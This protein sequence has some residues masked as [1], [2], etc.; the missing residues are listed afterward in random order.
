MDAQ[1]SFLCQAI[2]QPSPLTLEPNP[3]SAGMFFRRGI[4]AQL[5]LLNFSVPRDRL[6]P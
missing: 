2:P 4:L 5:Q 3:P 6:L 1:A